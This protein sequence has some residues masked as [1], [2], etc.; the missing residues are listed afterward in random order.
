LAEAEARFAAGATV[1]LTTLAASSTESVERIMVELVSDEAVTTSTIEGELLDRDSVQ[2]SIRR[3]LSLGLPD[4]AATPAER[5]IAELLVDVCRTF[6]QPLDAG[7]LHR[8]HAMVMRG[9]DARAE[10]GRWRTSAEPMQVVSGRLN[11]PTVH[12]EA[13]PAERVPGEMQRFIEWFNA[14]EPTV[15]APTPGALARAG[16]AHVWFESI[17]PFADGNGRVGRAL[18]EKALA[19]SMPHPSLTALS[20]VILA[21]RS[22]Y[23]RALA[24]ASTTLDVGPWQRWFAGIALQAQARSIAEVQ[25]I[26]AKVRML[27]ALGRDLNVRQEK[28]L[29]RMMERGST[30]FEG[31][32]T[33]SKYMAITRASP[34]TAT[35]DLAG[36]AELGA[37]VPHGARRHMRYELQLP[38]RPV[39]TITVLPTGAIVETVPPP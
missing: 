22:D 38:V 35:R 1:L 3:A 10:P 6:T 27:A 26:A 34:A 24:Q 25:F 23:Y 5:G 29:L 39:P 16:L 17:H 19:Q 8:W 36:L 7:T 14:T 20:P 13:P 32:M 2:R 37:L 28:A 9:R 18:S 15:D 4:A 33:A 30:G 12:F 31:G 11:R 21:R